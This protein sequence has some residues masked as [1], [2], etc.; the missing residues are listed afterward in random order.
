MVL[1]NL[2]DRVQ[3]PCRVRGYHPLWPAVPDRS[4]ME[5]L[6]TFTL[7]R[8]R[9]LQTFKSHNTSMAATYDLSLPRSLASP[10]SVTMLVWAV[11][12]SFATTRG[13]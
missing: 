1:E 13:I 5:V 10:R 4:T 11:P 3:N 8:I 6:I 2:N 7:F 9:K 12:V